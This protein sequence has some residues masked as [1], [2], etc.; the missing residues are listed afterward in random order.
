MIEGLSRANTV[1]VLTDET[2]LS[3]RSLRSAFLGRTSY[4]AGL[5]AQEQALNELREGSVSAVVLGLEHD[6]VVTLG[7]RGNE[8]SD[9]LATSQRVHDLGYEVHHTDRGGQ[10]TVHA[11]GQL[12]I[13]PCVNLKTY[14]L[15]AR[16][17]VCLINRV[18][19]ETLA[20]SG[21]QTDR[22]EGEPGL[23]VEGRKLV[24]FGFKISRG[25]S[26]HGLAINVSNSLEG[27]ELIRTCGVSKQPVTRLLDLRGEGDLETLFSSWA[28]HFQ[29]ALA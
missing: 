7:V 11:P 6:P 12:V 22:C 15:G 23:F 26:S 18:T 10:A 29:R 8:A 9:L 14:S 21:V 20:E 28:R 17:F 16:D 27:F 2:A 1:L 5:R 3:Q 19:V 4:D 13:Y 25:L 24:A